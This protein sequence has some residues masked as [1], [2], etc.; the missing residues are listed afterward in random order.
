MTRNFMR[1]LP[2]RMLLLTL[3]FGA[4]AC[5]LA[6]DQPDEANADRVARLIRQ[7]GD[8]DFFI[9]E[10]AQAELAGIGFE[11]FDAL[12][13]AETDD[14]IEIAARARFLLRKMR[15]QW[16]ADS[17]PLAV[18][19][20]L[21]DYEKADQ[22]NRLQRMQ[23][24]AQL[25]DDAGLSALCRLVRFEQTPIL[26]KHAALRIIEQPTTDK[27]D[28]ARREKAIQ[29][30]LQRSHR[31]P[32]KWLT[33]YLEGQH[34]LDAAVTEWA[35]LA[36][37]EDQTRQQYPDQSQPEIV[38]AL[39]RQQVEWLDR[40]KRSDDTLEVLK[41]M[42]ELAGG[43]ADALR[44]LAVQ[45]YQLADQRDLRGEHDSAQ[46]VADQA[47]SVNAGNPQ[48]HYRVSLQLKQLGMFKWA[49]QEFRHVI[50]IGPPGRDTALVSQWL[51]AEMLHD[52]EKE[53]PAAE[54]LQASAAA[55]QE[56]VRQGNAQQ[57]RAREP[58]DIRARMHYFFANHFAE[59]GDRARQIEHLEA[60]VKDN[61]LDADVLIGMYRL[62]EQTPEWKQRT[63]Q[64]IKK[65]AESFRHDIESNPDD[66]LNSDP[67]NQLAWLIGNTEGDYAE[68]VK[69][70]LKSIELGLANPQKINVGGY[71][72]TL[73]RCY[74]A[75][76]DLE[77]AVKNQTRAVELD[78]H[79]GQMRRQLELFQKALAE[80]QK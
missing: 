10:R 64:L 72:D 3:L 61:A 68:A 67:Y 46:Q 66:P 35:E 17:D 63:V 43:D 7:L 76:G 45:L 59:Q 23:R 42:V 55:M 70:S 65:A 80:K 62:P 56:N 47:R 77:N 39:L 1:R 30:T 32:A 20:I 52:Q 16:A 27:T 71:Y 48:E 26:S 34:N 41:K 25:P 4:S 53:L 44:A 74:Y 69:A 73:G 54:V 78:P 75:Q 60:A 58:G 24:L 21:K 49:E 11:A 18:K 79:S 19:E 2:I 51:L 8:N 50:S 22:P 14:D 9:R 15:I 13:D 5:A 33:T 12:S 31:P 6:V 37:M 38:M 36:A 40:L 28:W 57:N 29:E